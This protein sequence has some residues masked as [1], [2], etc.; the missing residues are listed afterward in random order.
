[1]WHTHTHTHWKNVSFALKD[2]AIGALHR[3]EL[4][5]RASGNLIICS[6]DDGKGAPSKCHITP[7]SALRKWQGISGGPGSVTFLVATGEVGVGG[8]SPSLTGL[9]VFAALLAKVVGWTLSAERFPLSGFGKTPPSCCHSATGMD[10]DAALLRGKNAVTSCLKFL[11][12]MKPGIPFLQIFQAIVIGEFRYL[13][14]NNN[15]RTTHKYVPHNL[16]SHVYY[17]PLCNIHWMA[18]LWWSLNT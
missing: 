9:W 6:L 11:I 7:D 17:L 2:C 16:H 15:N 8:E 4:S 14:I 5:R 3:G 10:Q 1:M 13:W 18:S 12:T